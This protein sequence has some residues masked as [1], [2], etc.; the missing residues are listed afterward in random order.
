M[1]VW[2]SGGLLAQIGVESIAAACAAGGEFMEGYA[3]LAL[4]LEHGPWAARGIVALLMRHGKHG[5]WR[6]GCR[7]LEPE[8]VLHILLVAVSRSVK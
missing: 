7:S 8:H 2:S 5:M 6:L 1:I 4:H 3:F